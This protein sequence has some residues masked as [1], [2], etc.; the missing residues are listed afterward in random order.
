M[1]APMNEDFEARGRIELLGAGDWAAADLSVAAEGEKA[2]SF[3]HRPSTQ[4]RMDDGR[5]VALELSEAQL[6]GGDEETLRGRWPELS[7]GVLGAVAT[8]YR[9]GP[10]VPL[11]LALRGVRNGALVTVRGLESRRGASSSKKESYR[12]VEIERSVRVHQIDAKSAY[13]K[14]SARPLDAESIT[15]AVALLTA[16]VCASLAWWTAFEA[17]GTFTVWTAAAFSAF[18]GTLAWRVSARWKGHWHFGDAAPTYRWLPQPVSIGRPQPRRRTHY[19]IRSIPPLVALPTLVLLVPVTCL[20][21]TGLLSAS[22]GDGI[23]GMTAAVALLGALVLLAED[24]I[25]LGSARRFARALATAPSTHG[26]TIA[27]GDLTGALT[28][29]VTM[30]TPMERRPPTHVEDCVTA[31]D[32]IGVAAAAIAMDGVEW[33]AYQWDCE[34]TK[35]PNLTRQTFRYS[36][37]ERSRAIAVYAGEPSA[38]RPWA[39]TGPSSLLL[40]TCPDDPV[41]TLRRALLVQRLGSIPL[42]LSLVAAL[43]AS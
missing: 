1:S 13:D 41:R 31:P 29:V 20:S 7:A 12:E 19:G 35:E 23:V 3:R 24:H 8:D 25:Y 28:R 22:K 11:T 30:V 27:N 14:P 18:A 4:L 32:R 10:H 16:L 37:G 5:L 21:V 26:W 6:I 36:A 43:L 38:D 39:V 15:W 42:V 34:L 9:P 40:F 2:R 33:A 17:G